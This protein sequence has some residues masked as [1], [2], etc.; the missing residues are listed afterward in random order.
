MKRILGFAPVAEQP[1]YNYRSLTRRRAREPFPVAIRLGRAYNERMNRIQP[2]GGT[3]ATVTFWGAAQVV[4][5]SMHLLE[6]GPL[7]VLLDCGLFQ[8]RREEAHRRN[9]RFATQRVR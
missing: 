1:G 2:T 7:K 4:T 8:G 6:S 3:G 5:G 9:A